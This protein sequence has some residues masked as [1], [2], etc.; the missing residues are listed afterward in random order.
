MSHSLGDNILL[1]I[2]HS[3]FY[4]NLLDLFGQILYYWLVNGAPGELLVASFKTL[5]IVSNMF[6][7]RATLEFLVNVISGKCKQIQGHLGGSVS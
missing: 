1:L 3:F 5:T 2:P 6:G 4:F 7:S